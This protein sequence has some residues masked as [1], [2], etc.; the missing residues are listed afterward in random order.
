ML[1]VAEEPTV[2]IISDSDQR[3][4]LLANQG[5][6][7]RLALGC[8]QNESELLLL[9][10]DGV[11]HQADHAGLLAFTWRHNGQRVHLRAGGAGGEC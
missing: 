3:L 9:F 8:S 2:F 5:A 7:W 1:C 10:V 6:V 4:L 11:V